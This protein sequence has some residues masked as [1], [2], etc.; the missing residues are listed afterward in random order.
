MNEYNDNF[1]GVWFPRDLWLD[2]NT[3]LVEKSVL[4]AI[5][6]LCWEY[7]F[8]TS[9]EIAQYVQCSRATVMRAMKHLK[10]LWYIDYARDEEIGL[11]RIL[12]INI[13]NPYKENAFIINTYYQNE[14]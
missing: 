12:K 14:K 10:E 13:T 5:N 7:D 3:S 2:R 6:D 1:K 8:I 11:N 9:N 4:V